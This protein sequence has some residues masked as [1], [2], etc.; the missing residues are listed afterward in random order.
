MTTDSACCTRW[1]VV[2]TV[3]FFH[4][5]RTSSFLRA[6]IEGTDVV[7]CADVFD[8][9]SFIA[10]VHLNPVLDVREGY[11][12]RFKDD[13]D[14]RV[15]SISSRADLILPGEGGDLTCG[16]DVG[17]EGFVPVREGEG[18]DKP[19]SLSGVAVVR[20][21]TERLCSTVINVSRSSISFDG[22]T[23]R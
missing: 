23:V 6:V 11:S 18:G 1:S 22:R 17:V 8:L 10:E 3:E 19:S 2:V 4:V 5:L 13:E 20:D 16:E 12:R 7:R 21:A 15:N 14:M 9:A